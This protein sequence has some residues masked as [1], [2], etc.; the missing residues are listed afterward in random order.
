MKPVYY[1]IQIGLT[2]VSAECDQ[3][4]WIIHSELCLFAFLYDVVY[5][6]SAFASCWDMR[7]LLRA[8]NVSNIHRKSC[9]YIRLAHQPKFSQWAFFSGRDFCNNRHLLSLFKNCW[10]NEISIRCVPWKCVSYSRSAPPLLGDTRH[11]PLVQ[12]TMYLNQ[13]T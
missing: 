10:H 2:S 5:E 8:Q 6:T 4:Y 13:G 7:T 3:K 9:Q 11:E 1:L 12:S